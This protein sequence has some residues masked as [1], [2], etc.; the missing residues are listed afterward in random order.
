MPKTCCICLSSK[1][2][3]K[4]ST[5]FPIPRSNEDLK[6]WEYILKREIPTV[7][8]ICHQHFDENYLIRQARRIMLNKQKIY[9]VELEFQSYTPVVRDGDEHHGEHVKNTTEYNQFSNP[10][11]LSNIQVITDSNS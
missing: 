1:G 11:A 3:S 10:P 5:F 8:Y 6:K 9:S 7:G 2:E 4:N